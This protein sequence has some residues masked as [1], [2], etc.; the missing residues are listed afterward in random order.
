MH[1]PNPEELDEVALLE[2][3]RPLTGEQSQGDNGTR[4]QELTPRER[5][6]ILAGMFWWR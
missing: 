2:L 5:E 6:L 1:V 3:R 4:W